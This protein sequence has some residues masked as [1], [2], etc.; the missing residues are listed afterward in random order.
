MT[1]VDRIFSGEVFI[2]ASGQ[3]SLDFPLAEYSGEKYIVVN[4]AIRAFI[5]LG[6]KPFA[7]VYDDPDF[8]E[9]NVELVIKAIEISEVIFMPR[10]LYVEYKIADKVS[11][12]LKTKINFISKVNKPDGVTLYPYRFFFIRNLFNRELV[13]KLSRLIYKS[14]NIGFSRDIEQ[15]YFCAR[16]IPYVALQLAYSLGFERVFFIGLDL[17]ESVG[18]FYDGEIPLPTTLDKDYPKHIYPSF[19]LVAKRIVC[20]KFKIYNLS[21]NSRLPETVIPKITLK[22]LRAILDEK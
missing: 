20:D 5:D 11:E 8:I 14:K 1:V 12:H 21:L 13:F 9:S 17:N 3:S 18:R 4:G 15:G 22:Q 19:K 2:Y 10:E 7:Y 16:T 6:I